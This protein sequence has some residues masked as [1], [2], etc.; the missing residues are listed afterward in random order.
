MTYSVIKDYRKNIKSIQD[1]IFKK[2]IEC[3]NTNNSS[4]PSEIYFQLNY[5]NES[6]KSD[7]KEFIGKI[8]YDIHSVNY[9]L[10]RLSELFW[11]T[12]Y[13]NMLQK[14]INQLTDIENYISSTTEYKKY[15]EDINDELTIPLF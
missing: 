5:I 12:K 8:K 4:L 7:K 14:N 3:D 13:S 15:L 2:F 10:R 6:I 11:N 1:K 9:D